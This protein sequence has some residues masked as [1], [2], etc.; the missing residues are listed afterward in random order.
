MSF[1]DNINTDSPSNPL[2]KEQKT[3]LSINKANLQKAT[4]LLKSSIEATTTFPEIKEKFTDQAD[5]SFPVAKTSKVGVATLHTKGETQEVNIPKTLAGQS[6]AKWLEVFNHGNETDFQN[7]EKNYSPDL[8]G[9]EITEFLKMVAKGSGGFDLKFLEESDSTHL[10][11]WVQEKEGLEM[12]PCIKF[13][14]DPDEPHLITELFLLSP[15]SKISKKVSRTLEQDAIELTNTHIDDLAR[16]NQFSGKII[17]TKNGESLLSRAV[18]LADIENQI[19]NSQ[20]TK[21]NIASMGKMFT[22]VAILQLLENDKLSLDDPIGEYLKTL[23][24]PIDPNGALAKVTI[25][26]LLTHTGGTGSIANPEF[27]NLIN[28]KDYVKAGCHRELEFTPG[29]QWSYSNF[30]FVLLGAVI[31]SV[32]GQDY[33]DY[34]QDNIY[35]KAAMKSTGAHLKADHEENQAIGYVKKDGR[36]LS[37][38]ELLPARGTP[39][40]GSYST[41]E[42]MQLFATALLNN[43]LLKKETLNLA[44]TPN[45]VTQAGATYCFGFMDGCDPEIKDDETI[46]RTVPWFGHEGHDNG[47]NAEL[48]I[49][50]ETGYI[51]SVM[52]NRSS[53]ACDLAEFIGARLPSK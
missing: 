14:V 4:D 15:D 8:N 7:F 30:G 12:Y 38:D 6:F 19:E 17:V 29:D 13:A 2:Y 51:V 23:D 52:S 45:Q 41:T 49:Y 50:P 26:Q 37:N 22:T 27:N 18:G 53:G 36:F 10:T 35:D 21:F 34:L 20:K 42:D 1:P 46:V 9:K 25:K 3:D 40:G 32:S 31:E 5:I 47:V 48:R 39:A 44:T 16:K 11:M 33:Y 43:Q 28:V 24:Y